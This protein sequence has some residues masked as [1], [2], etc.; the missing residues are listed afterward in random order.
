MSFIHPPVP[1][2]IRSL[3]DVFFSKL[4]LV[5]SIQNLDTEIYRKKTLNYLQ[6]YTE[7]HIL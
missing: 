6:N 2:R 4:C 3:T 7:N 1:Y 5:D